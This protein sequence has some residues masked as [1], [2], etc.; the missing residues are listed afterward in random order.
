[1]LKTDSRKRRP[2]DLKVAAK[3]AG[4]EIWKKPLRLFTKLSDFVISWGNQ[5]WQTLVGARTG[6]INAQPAEE[7]I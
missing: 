7:P 2:S 3:S 5:K 4:L 6:H 1:L